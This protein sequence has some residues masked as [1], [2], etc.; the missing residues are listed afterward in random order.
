MRSRP[1]GSPRSGVQA[2]GSEE[3][4]VV[5]VREEGASISV[6]RSDLHM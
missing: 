4:G 1:D 2:E 3:H 6:S 5:S